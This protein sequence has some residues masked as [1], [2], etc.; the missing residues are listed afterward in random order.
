MQPRVPEPALNWP[1]S[2]KLDTFKATELY[3][4]L[5]VP[6]IA[7]FDSNLHEIRLTDVEEGDTKIAPPFD[8]ALLEKVHT[9]T[10]ADP[11]TYNAPPFPSA[12]PP[13]NVIPF[14]VAE[15]EIQSIRFL[16]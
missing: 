11:E 4:S 9:L 3:T 1:A 7:V 10:T 2:Q 15:P 12:I 13:V 6:L 5:P 8:A 16:L 14:S